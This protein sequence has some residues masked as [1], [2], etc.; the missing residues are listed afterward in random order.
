[1]HGR[2]IGD[3]TVDRSYGK[4]SEDID[5]LVLRGKKEGVTSMVMD[6]GREE[7]IGAKGWS[8]RKWKCQDRGRGKMDCPMLLVRNK[9]KWKINVEE[10][11]GADTYK[12]KKS[13]KVK[14]QGV[15]CAKGLAEAVQQPGQ[16]Q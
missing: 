9:K 5:I 6:E 7:I 4:S 1:M 8:V 16:V 13:K 3:Q 12:R 2:R 15:D 11:G 10:I 14:S